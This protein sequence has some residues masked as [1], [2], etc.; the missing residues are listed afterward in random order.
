MFAVEYSNNSSAMTVIVFIAVTTTYF[1]YKELF[2]T[3]VLYN[4]LKKVKY[5]LSLPENHSFLMQG[6]KT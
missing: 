5:H 6:T 1:I 4:D 3:T 2:E